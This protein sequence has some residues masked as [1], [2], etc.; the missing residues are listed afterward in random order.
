MSMQCERKLGELTHTDVWGPARVS[1]LHGYHY[2][3]SFIDDATRHCTI[4]FMKTK[5]ETPTKVK[6]YLACI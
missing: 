1:F 2:Y 6:Q 4:S 3:V 5:D